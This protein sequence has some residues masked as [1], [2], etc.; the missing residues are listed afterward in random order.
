MNFIYI[1]EVVFRTA[2]GEKTKESFF[3]HDAEELAEQFFKIYHNVD[4]D[5]IGKRREYGNH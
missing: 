1:Y 5:I 3:A 4:Y 2:T